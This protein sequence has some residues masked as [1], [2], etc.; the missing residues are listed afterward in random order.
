MSSREHPQDYTNT[1][2]NASLTSR[3]KDRTKKKRS[4]ENRRS[5]SFIAGFFKYSTGAY[6]ALISWCECT[7]WP[8][9]SGPSYP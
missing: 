8:R 4:G 6:E 1:I 2:E 7:R 5:F 9:R 3:R